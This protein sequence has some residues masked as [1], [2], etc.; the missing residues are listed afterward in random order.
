MMTWD[1]RRVKQLID[2]TRAGGRPRS[3]W[4]NVFIIIKFI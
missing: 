1:E 4:A 2:S 3:F